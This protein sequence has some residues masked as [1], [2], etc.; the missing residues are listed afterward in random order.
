MWGKVLTLDKLQ[1]RGWQLPN[2]CYLCGCALWDIIFAIVGAHWIFPKTVKDAI[3][4]WRDSFVGKKRKK[5]WNA[6]PICIFWIVWKE[7]NHIGFKEGK[8]DV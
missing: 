1:R 3:I 5:V 4:S 7:R 8:I 2:R 6:V